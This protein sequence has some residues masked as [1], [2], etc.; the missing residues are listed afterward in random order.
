MTRAIV[1]VL[2]LS[3]AACASD[4]D[5]IYGCCLGQKVVGNA[6][7]VTVFNVYNEMDALP[8]AERHCSQFKRT[9]RF[10]RMEQ[11]RAIFDCV[12]L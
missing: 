2:A 1:V 3:V 11:F 6:A 8:L 4:P 5:N 9:P 10:N 12:T 7:Y